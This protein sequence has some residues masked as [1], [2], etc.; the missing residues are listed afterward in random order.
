MEQGAFTWIEIWKFH[1]TALL[2]GCGIDWLIGDPAWLPHPIRLMGSMILWLEGR[3]RGWIPQKERTGGMILTA[4]M[5]LVWWGIPF[6]VFCGAEKS[7][8]PGSWIPLLLIE[9]IWCS[10]M[11]AARGL[12]SE[13]MKVCRSLE[14]GK[15]EEARINVSMIVG[16]DTA[17]L[18]SDGIARAA[19]ETVAE[20]A[21]DGVIAPFLFLAFFG[22]WGGSLYK[23]V[24]TMD[25]MIGYKNDRYRYFGRAA[26]RLDDCLNLLPARITGLL[27]ILGAWLL[28]GMDARQAWRI[29]L[30]DRKCH[31]SPN[32]AHGEAACAGALHL[33]LAGDA[34]YFGTLHKKPFIGDEGRQIEPND[35]RR[36]N[37]LMFA[38]EGIAMGILGAGVLLL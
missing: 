21:S 17:P 10:Q 12:Y 31:A 38:A 22:P 34:W 29:F 26:A 36:A 13:S 15:T 35:I 2:L 8:L 3:I 6:L 30:R 33:R 1:S 27:M 11:L 23:A 7:L 19:V 32:S 14:K 20:N 16:R 9:S 4:V 37:G 5:C 18:D 25:S 28:P 24:N